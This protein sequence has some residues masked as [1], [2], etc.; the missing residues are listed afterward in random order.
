MLMDAKARMMKQLSVGTD[1]IKKVEEGEAMI[2]RDNDGKDRLM[3]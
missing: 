1:I 3:Q 2:S